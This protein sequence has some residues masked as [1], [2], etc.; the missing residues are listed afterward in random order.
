MDQ[1]NDE[2]HK[3]W[4]LTTKIDETT[5]FKEIKNPSLSIMKWSLW[6]KHDQ[7]VTEL[8]KKNYNSTYAYV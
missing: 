8:Y 5:V 3:N 7:I 1:L 2:I 6:S 4:Y